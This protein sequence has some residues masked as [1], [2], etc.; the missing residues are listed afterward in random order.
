MFSNASI[1]A[2]LRGISLIG[3][4]AVILTAGVGSYGLLRS[5]TGLEAAITA[6]TAVLHQKQADMMHDALRADVLNALVIRAGGRR[7][8]A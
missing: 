2:R 3:I 1:S 5:N 4:P 8:G 7:R 6:T